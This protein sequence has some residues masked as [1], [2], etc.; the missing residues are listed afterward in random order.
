[1]KFQ[2]TAQYL[3]HIFPGLALNHERLVSQ[4]NL[5]LG[6]LQLLRDCFLAWEIDEPKFWMLLLCLVDAVNQ[7]SLCL[8]LKHR[9]VQKQL[10]AVGLTQPTAQAKEHNWDQ[11]LLNEQSLFR[12]ENAC[13]YFTKYW[14]TEH[15]LQEALLRLLSEYNGTRFTSS[16][17]ADAA[18][19]VTE[20]L[21]FEHIEDRQLLAIVIS[22]LKPFS[23]ISGGPGT[24]KTTIMS[25]VLRGLMYLGYHPEDV[26]LAAPTG[27]AANRMTE[28]MHEVLTQHIK[29]PANTDAGLQSIKAKTIHRLL[30]ARA[31]WRGFQYGAHNLLDCKVLVIDEVSMVDVALMRQLLQA[32]PLDCRVVLL[33]DQ[34]QLPSVNSGS[35]L[36]DLMP[37][38]DS[39]D[40][41][42]QS[43]WQDLTKALEKCTNKDS[44]LAELNVVEQGYL[45]TDHVTVLTV[46]KRSQSNISAVSELIRQGDVSGL[47][48]S[49]KLQL[50]TEQGNWSDADL[51]GVSLVQATEDIRAWQN[52]YLNWIKFHYFKSQISFKTLISEL[53]GFDENNLSVYQSH[54]DQIFKVI[55][56][57][58]ILT[59]VNDSPVGSL[60]IN[61]Q[62][63]DL[64]K[65]QLAVSGVGN[66]FHGSVIMM[67]RNNASLHLFNGDV[68]VLL[69]ASSGQLRVVLPYKNAYISHSVH[70][71]PS[72]TTAYAM[73]VHKS[74]GS[75]FNHVLMPLPEDVNHRLL[76]REIIYTGM[77][78]A[79][80]SVVL[81]AHSA[82]LQAAV[83]R[84]TT[85]HSGLHFW[86]N[87]G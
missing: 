57:N 49:P 32:V 35:V 18:M 43:M 46:S 14:Q 54:L 87:Q 12:M 33:G 60:Q 2:V 50:G 66:S 34:F 83:K 20:D 7:G 13:L 73:T 38:V 63:T 27:R 53:I 29:V 76:S 55:N 19:Q 39:T 51:S 84:Q 48:K 16:Q 17:V 10:R 26:V 40:Q 45:L 77:T 44:V 58:R 59:L 68:G 42:S 85:R 64:M 4:L 65:Q 56:S 6:H 11:L 80:Q 71:I 47:F 61:A 24:G 81:Y 79:K 5:D 1:M 31:Q 70:V 41:Y 21:S 3:A 75:E 62:I 82:A 37:P 23:I 28:S 78:R 9:A 22:L 30:G 69:A 72:F 15:E 67:G 8:D 52:D 36:A 25:S 86:Y 74:Q